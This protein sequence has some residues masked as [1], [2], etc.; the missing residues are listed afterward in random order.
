[1]RVIRPFIDTSSARQP[2]NLAAQPQRVDVPKSPLGCLPRPSEGPAV[3]TATTILAEQRSARLRLPAYVVAHAG[4]GTPA[5]V[6]NA[7]IRS[8]SSR[9]YCGFA[10]LSRDPPGAHPCRLSPE[11]LFTQL[12]RQL[13]TESNA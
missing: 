4:C 11:T 7:A 1:M 9:A 3:T 10:R 13:G 6:P 12:H 8:E 2:S 5:T